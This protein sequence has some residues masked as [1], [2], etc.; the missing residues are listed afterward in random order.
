MTHPATLLAVDPGR[1]SGIAYYVDGLLAVATTTTCRTKGDYRDGGDLI[2]RAF[3]ETPDRLVIEKP[4]IY[5]RG[6]G[7]TKGDPNGLRPLLQLIGYLAH[8]YRGTELIEVEPAQWKGQAAK[9][10][11]RAMSARRLSPAELAV[12]PPRLAHDGWDAIAIGLWGLGRFER[13]RVFHGASDG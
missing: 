7:V 13:K 8:A 2:I 6:A 10:A 11:T 1:C 4:R 5:Q 9:E 3:P 12:I